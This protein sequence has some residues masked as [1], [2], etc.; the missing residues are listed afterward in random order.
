MSRLG[1]DPAAS[2]P[3]LPSLNSLP[4]PRLRVLIVDD[5]ANTAATL[6]A[7]LQLQGFAVQTAADGPRALEAVPTFRP[8]VVLLDLAL[9]RMHGYEVARRLRTD[10]ADKPPLVVAFSGY[11][12]DRRRSEE[13]GI[14]LHLLKPADL[15]QL[16]GLLKRL[17][18]GGR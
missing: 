2:G 16:V 5:D 14:A 9:P 13:A 18:K 12:E 11:G 8:D 4:A 1:P 7:L 15:D 17:H 6:A 10:P 3:P